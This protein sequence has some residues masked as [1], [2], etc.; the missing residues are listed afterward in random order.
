M[1]LHLITFFSLLL[2]FSQVSSVAVPLPLE[3]FA[4]EDVVIVEAHPDDL[5]VAMGATVSE[6]TSIGA[7]VSIIIITNGNCGCGN[8]LW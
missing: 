7:N 5:E 8:P 4:R 2:A 6:L 1:I 3:R